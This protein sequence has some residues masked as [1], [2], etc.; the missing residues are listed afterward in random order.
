MSVVP[1]LPNVPNQAVCAP[2]TRV[3]LSVHCVEKLIK[4]EATPTMNFAQGTLTK[5]N[6][7]ITSLF[8]V[9]DI[10]R[11]VPWICMS[12]SRMILYKHACQSAT[13]IMKRMDDVSDHLNVLHDM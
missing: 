5:N 1:I 11:N 10:E 3:W 13:E 7:S 6:S 9:S 2:R 8:T 4:P 12:Q